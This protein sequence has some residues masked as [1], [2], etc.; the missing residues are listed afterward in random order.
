MTYLVFDAPK[1]GGAY[2]ERV[3]WLKKSIKKEKDSTYAAVVGVKKCDSLKHMKLMLQEVLKKNGE[4]L[5]LR[6][7]ES[8]YENKRSNTLLKV[9]YFHDEECRV[10]ESMKGTGRCQ[11]MMGKLQC[12]LPNGT[13]FKVGTGFSDAQRKKPPKVGSIITFK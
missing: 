1:H 4:G 2:E 3:A 7:P 11:D 10:T 13:K 6:Q 5:M 12:E 8:L 9:K